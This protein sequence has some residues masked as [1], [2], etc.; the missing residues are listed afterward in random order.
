MLTANLDILMSESVENLK[1]MMTW[2][3]TTNSSQLADM[4]ADKVWEIN[5][6]N[7]VDCV[8]NTTDNTTAGCAF[9]TAF[10][11]AS[12]VE[13]NAA[14]FES[15]Y[16]NTTDTSTLTYESFYWGVNSSYQDSF[17]EIELIENIT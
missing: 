2:M 14:S 5:Y 4:I 9:V 11:D 16:P 17:T 10:V 6:K 1:N 8:V 3:D 15:L 12:G 7:P 13:D